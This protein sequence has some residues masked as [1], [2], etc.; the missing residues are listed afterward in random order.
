MTTTAVHQIEQNESWVRRVLLL[1]WF[2]IAYNVVEGVVAMGF[3]VA[4]ESVALFGFGADSFIE[5]F[6]AIV[7][8]WR[9]RGEIGG[10]RMA[11]GHRRVA[12]QQE[13]RDR[14]ADEPTP[15]DDDR[16]RAAQRDARLVE[17]RGRQPVVRGEDG[18]LVT[19]PFRLAKVRDG[20]APWR[21]GG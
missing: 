6:S 12:F 14:L 15:P 4:D 11:H 20:H 8:L 10:A 13:Q 19:G 21:I 1:S 18:Q 5:V 9:F 7:V 16:M 2:T 17:D 3:G